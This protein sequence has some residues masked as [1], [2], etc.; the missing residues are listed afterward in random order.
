[1]VG[2]VLGDGGHLLGILREELYERVE[3]V[4]LDLVGEARHHAGEYP[5]WT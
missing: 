2:L 5:G 1:V 4:R 3:V